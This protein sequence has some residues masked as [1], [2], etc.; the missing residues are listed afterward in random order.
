MLQEALAMFSLLERQSAF[1]GPSE[2]EKLET[3]DPGLTCMEGYY[4]SEATVYKNGKE[5]HEIDKCALPSL[6]H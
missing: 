1:Y 2:L 4:H 6:L 5:S 3:I